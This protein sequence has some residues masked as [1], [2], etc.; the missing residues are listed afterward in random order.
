MRLIKKGKIEEL[1]ESSN[2]LSQFTIVRDALKD[3][4]YLLNQVEQASLNANINHNS[5]LPFYNFFSDKKR[6][7]R[8]NEEL[9]KSKINF[10]SLFQSLEKI[11]GFAKYCLIL[12]HIECYCEDLNQTIFEEFT[13]P[14]INR[15]GKPVGGLD[16][17]CFI[18]NKDKSP[19][20]LHVDHDHTFIF[21]VGP[22][23]KTFLLWDDYFSAKELK[24][25]NMLAED[26]IK[27]V[28]KY[29]KRI[30]L[31]PNDLLFI[32]K[33]VPHYA[34]YQFPS[35][36]FGVTLFPFYTDYIWFYDETN[37]TDKLNRSQFLNSHDKDIENNFFLK[38]PKY[39][40]GKEFKEKKGLE[41][42]MPLAMKF[43]TTPL[44]EDLRFN[45]GENKNT[46]KP[47]YKTAKIHA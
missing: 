10:S 34:I 15:F 6:I 23:D 26:E 38:Y 2:E 37:S 45:Q 41:V 42:S 39:E 1:I 28:E 17:Y 13:S 29:A 8:V 12:N 36:M 3:T 4:N 35:I 16:Y 21:H 47:I 14:L 18:G 31:K 30:T 43:A 24:T 25:Y 22:N 27:S 5:D 33:D 9:L 46:L 20:G 44:L 32:P 7:E 19:P 40:G 11:S